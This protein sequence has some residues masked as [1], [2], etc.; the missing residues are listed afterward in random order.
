M[1]Y[2]MRMC[3]VAAA[4]AAALVACQSAAADD[5]QAAATPI[6]P[7]PE[8][9]RAEIVVPAART[10]PL[11]VEPMDL[12]TLARRRGG[13]DVFND[14]Q[15]KGVVADNRAINVSTGNN[16]ITDGALAASA[17]VPMVVQNTGNNVLI[18]NATIISVQ[19]K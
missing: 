14:M 11:G 15:L 9:A 2:A 7:L 17:G 10:N 13:T 8:S 4:T 19:V 6:S 3:L 5:V 12:K 1:S 16:S 18:Q